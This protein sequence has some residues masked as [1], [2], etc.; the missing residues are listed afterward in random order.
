MPS[1]EYHNN[2]RK[3]YQWWRTYSDLKI[4]SYSATWPHAQYFKQISTQLVSKKEKGI[5]LPLLAKQS[6]NLDLS[7]D[8]MREAGKCR[9]PVH[10]LEYRRP[11][12]APRRYSFNVHGIGVRCI[13]IAPLFL[14]SSPVLFPSPRF[15]ERALCFPMSPTFII[16]FFLYPT[17][18]ASCHAQTNFPGSESQLGPPK[19]TPGPKLS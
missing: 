7:S 6:I 11:V 16:L 17:Q 15:R 5:T 18:L 9:A 3:V 19:G 12:S 1:Q 8:T 2:W 10:W 13:I 14:Y 4:S